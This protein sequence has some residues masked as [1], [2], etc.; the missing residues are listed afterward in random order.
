MSV[1][2][3]IPLKNFIW[4]PTTCQYIFG[5][6]L[7]RAHSAQLDMGEIH[8]LQLHTTQALITCRCEQRIKKTSPKGL[9]IFWYPHGESWNRKTSE[10]AHIV[11]RQPS[12][13]G[14]GQR[15]CA[16]AV[17]NETWGWMKNEEIKMK[18]EKALN[19]S[20][21]FLVPPWG[22]E[23]QIPPWEGDVLTAWPWGHLVAKQ[24]NARVEGNRLCIFPTMRAFRCEMHLSIEHIKDRNGRK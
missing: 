7:L 8:L 12:V 20:A 1:I 23:P 22:I 14:F 2:H 21:L 18:N 9:V 3:A 17:C 16:H 19:A 4:Q 10:F 13:L 6:N 15:S 24:I 5:H 11:K